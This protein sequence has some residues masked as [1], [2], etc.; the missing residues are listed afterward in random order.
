VT[1][2]GAASVSPQ[3]AALADFDASHGQDLAALLRVPAP[4]EP[5][6]FVEFWRDLHTRAGQVA[7]QAQRED[8]LPGDPRFRVFAVSFQA[9]DDVR[10]GGWLVEPRQGAAKAGV[11]FGHGYGGRSAP[12]LGAA[13]PRAA[14]LFFCSRGFDR[15]MSPLVPGYADGHV[16]HGIGSRETYAHRG[17]AAD[18]WASASALLELVPEA[19]RRLLYAG[20]SFG[21]G[22]GALALPWDARF[23]GAHLDVP[24]FGNHPLRATLRSTGSGEA[25]R[26]HLAH[27]PEALQ[28]LA[29]FDAATAA[30]HLRIPTQVAAA[31]FDP[32]VPPPGQ[33]AVYNAL[34]GPKELFVRQ[35][36]HVDHPGV[37]REDRA[38]AEHW[39]EWLITDR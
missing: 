8:E 26:R 18:V 19:G 31:L 1:P 25:V 12:E 3:V 36:G 24:S 33:F 15:S 2:R 4:P 16:V 7:P 23:A 39:Q 9:L 14:T 21:G 35:A 30:T 13:P 22:I 37:F 38:V 5:P 20:C 6:G 11:V 27:H 32:A 34:P 28:V 29:Y 17:A 10:L